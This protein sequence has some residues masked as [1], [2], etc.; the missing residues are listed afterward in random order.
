MLHRNVHPLS[1]GSSESQRRQKC[2]QV[3]FNS[4]L[5]AP[6]G[7]RGFITVMKNS[8]ISTSVWQNYYDV[9]KLNCASFCQF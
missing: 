4:K 5:Y 1:R 7:L 8:F 2:S 3:G 9:E 6:D